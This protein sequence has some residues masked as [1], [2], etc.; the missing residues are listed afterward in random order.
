MADLFTPEQPMTTAIVEHKDTTPLTILEQIAGGNPTPEVLRTIAEII[1]RQDRNRAAEAFGQAMTRF[2]TQC[3]II[4]KARKANLGQGFGYTF[5]SYDDIHRQISPLLAECQLAISFST[6]QIDGQLKATCRVRHGIHFEDHTLTV[7]VPAMKV[8]DTQRFGAALSY[9][10]R[11]ALCAAL[12][13][14]VTDEDPDAE[15]LVETIGEDEIASLKELIESTGTDLKRF[16]DWAAIDELKN[17]SRDFFPAAIQQL[18][19]KQKQ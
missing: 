13:I 3:P 4:H 11:Y 9:A 14:V 12:N 1:E 15:G 17:M 5:A 7:P 10:K 16:L 18:R 19:R 8:N 6:E 2:Q